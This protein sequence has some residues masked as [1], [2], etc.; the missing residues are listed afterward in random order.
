MTVK[1]F[2]SMV[3]DI[4]EKF[5]NKIVVLQKDSEGNGYLECRGI[6]WSDVY[7]SPEDNEVTGPDFVEDD[8]WE[9]IINESNFQPCIILYP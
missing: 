5:D 6:D 1:I 2:K 3:N 7:F 9:D 8:E 4:P